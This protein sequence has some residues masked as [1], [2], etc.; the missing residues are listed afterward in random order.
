MRRAT[1]SDLVIAGAG[2]QALS[3]CCQLL[4][5][6]PYWRRRVRIL[7]PSGRW[8]SRWERQMR[9]FEIP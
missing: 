5:K 1:V 9:Q 3:L 2:P 4:Q 7:D 8:L 6:R